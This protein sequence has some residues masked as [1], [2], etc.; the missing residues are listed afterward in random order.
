MTSTINTTP[1]IEL[2]QI[3][4]AFDAFERRQLIPI[5]LQPHYTSN[6]T[7]IEIITNTYVELCQIDQVLDANQRRQLIVVHLDDIA[8]QQ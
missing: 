3:D 5:R 7:T 6:I 2:C 1:H 4:Q 8:H